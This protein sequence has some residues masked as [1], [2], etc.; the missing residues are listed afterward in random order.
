MTGF[1]T[2]LII[3]IFESFILFLA[4]YLFGFGMMI[5]CVFIIMLINFIMAEIIR[6]I[7]EGDND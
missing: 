7:D 1:H 3:T 4:Y 5:I 2:N 6:Y